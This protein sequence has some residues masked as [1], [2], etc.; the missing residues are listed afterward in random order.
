MTREFRRFRQMSPA[1]QWKDL[2][3]SGN[4][5]AVETLRALLT[6]RRTAI[7]DVDDYYR[8]LIAESRKPVRQRRPLPASED[9]WVGVVMGIDPLD[10]PWLFDRARTE[11]ALLEVALAVRMHYLQH[12]RYPAHLTDISKQWLPAVP[13]DLWDQ[14]IA[15][16][17]KNGQPIIYSLG[18][19]GKDDGGLPIDATRLTPTTRGDLVFGLMSHRLHR[20]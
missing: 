8:R 12:G 10:Q 1:Q 4:L 7:A 2:S 19:D 9:Y 6:P 13:T 20:R 3:S 14:P 18:P 5:G 15:F 17:L 16:R 11:L